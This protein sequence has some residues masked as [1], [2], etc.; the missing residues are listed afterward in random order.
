MITILNRNL[1]LLA[2][3]LFK[4][5]N[6]LLLFLLKEFFVENAQHYD[7]KKTEFKKKKYGNGVQCN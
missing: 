1:L 4:L 6:G 5:N 2:T 3:E 7:L